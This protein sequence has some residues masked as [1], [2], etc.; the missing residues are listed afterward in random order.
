MTIKK[1]VMVA[2]SGGVDSAVT[3]ALLKEEGYEVIGATMCFSLPES[4]EDRKKPSCCGVSGIE[5]ARK[6]AYALGIKHYVFSFGKALQEKVVKNFLSEYLS[7]R[8]P[9][10]CV[11]CNQFLKSDLL[12]KKTQQFGCD[13]LATGHYAKFSY[14][15]LRRR[16]R[17]QRAKDR[18]KDQSYFLY[19]I[20]KEILP[21]LL[22]PLGDYT[23]DEVRA[24]ARSFKLIVSDKPG[25]QEIC[26][27]PSD[28]YRAFIAERL[29]EKIK[30]G[31]IKD[32][33]GKVL[34][35]H[36]GIAF[37]TIG[38]R[39]ALGGGHAT[40]LFVIKIDN[41][42]NTIILGEGKAVYAKALIADSLNFFASLPPK[43]TVAISAKIRY[44]H[45]D[46]K[47]RLIPLGRDTVKVEF[48]LPQ[49]AVTPGQ[50]VVFYKG[51]IVLGGGI[52]RESIN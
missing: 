7:G 32:L 11:R 44:N 9:N 17:L 47:S 30:P 33:R 43:K 20:K 16:Y 23:K 51:D 50:S 19:A 22:F 8:T 6:T 35:E 15:M 52:I 28:D 39:R 49:R 3:A 2:M 37:Y 21:H 25:S 38:Q 5:D 29:M 26:F 10:P 45:Q 1:R 40:P 13:Y 34:G 48:S 24:L 41:T 42:N 31:F 12:F 14:D 46:I 36:K 18:K 4:T 27:I